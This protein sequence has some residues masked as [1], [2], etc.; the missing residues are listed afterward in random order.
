MS[1]KLIDLYYNKYKNYTIEQMFNDLDN[2]TIHQLLLELS[3]QKS[4]QID[5]NQILKKSIIR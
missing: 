1:N 5:S 3:V 4:K 2:N